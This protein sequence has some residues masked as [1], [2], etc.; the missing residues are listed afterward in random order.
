MADVDIK[1]LL[2]ALREVSAASN[3][4]DLDPNDNPN[5]SDRDVNDDPGND[6]EDADSDP[7]SYYP[8]DDGDDDEDNFSR[9]RI[10][11]TV[12]LL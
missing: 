6:D 8:D 2:A 12:M 10:L 9:P 1:D 7:R 11:S 4:D 5:D 3:P